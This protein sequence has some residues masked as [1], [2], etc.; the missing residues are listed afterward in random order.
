MEEMLWLPLLLLPLSRIRWRR[1][2]DY[3]YYDYLS[4]ESDGGD[5]YDYHYYYLSVEL[6]GEDRY[7]YH[8]YYYYL[9]VESDRGDCFNNHYY[10]YLSV[11]SDGGDRYDYLS[12]PKKFHTGPSTP[13]R[14]LPH[15]LAHRYPVFFLNLHEMLG[16]GSL[17]VR[18][19]NPVTRPSVV[20]LS[21]VG[22]LL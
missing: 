8:Y 9:S 10:Y 21:I 14:N 19:V 5:R 7:D 3:H 20:I 12:P 17:A 18:S 6:D 1:C 22:F 4:V 13:D 15:P 11:E 2:Y 16:K